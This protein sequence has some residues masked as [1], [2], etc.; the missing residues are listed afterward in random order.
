MLVF[1]AG[2]LNTPLVLYMEHMGFQVRDNILIFSFITLGRVLS[3]LIAGQLTDQIGTKKVFFLAHVVLC[4]VSF[5]VVYVGF[6]PVN[7]IK[8]LMPIAMISSG[9]SS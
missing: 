8:Y 5:S 3:L 2:F 4:I 9:W 7:H 1:A 6:L